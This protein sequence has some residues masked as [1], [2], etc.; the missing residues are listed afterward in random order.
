MLSDCVKEDE[1]RGAFSSEVNTSVI[2]SPLYENLG[3]VD[4]RERACGPYCPGT[5]DTVM[6]RICDVSKQLQIWMVSGSVSLGSIQ[7]TEVDEHLRM[8]CDVDMRQTL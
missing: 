8:I 7:Y 6:H 3:G 4:S 1:E 2:Y 5:N